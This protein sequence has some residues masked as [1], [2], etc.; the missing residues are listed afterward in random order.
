MKENKEVITPS[1]EE[2]DIFTVDE[3]LLDK[4]WTN[5]PKQ[6]FKYAIMLDEAQSKE[7]RAKQRLEEV[8]ASI[9]FAIRTNPK[10]YKLPGTTEACI[11]AS[12]LLQPE[13]KGALKKLNKRTD[14]TSTL[15]SV[16]SSLD[17][18]TKA[19]EN[20]VRLHG[21]SYFSVPK[22]SGDSKEYIDEKTKHTARRKT[23]ARKI[24]K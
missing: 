18:K 11:K 20:A 6:Y 5:H 10:K 3:L 16:I 21:Q 9:G 19:L 14:R 8:E 4:E 17:K 15:K 22:A 13:Y 1:E 7:R 23:G 24:T 2:F 12:V